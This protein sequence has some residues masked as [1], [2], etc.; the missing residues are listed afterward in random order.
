MA[1]RMYTRRY[2]SYCVRAKHLLDEL[3]VAYQEISVDG[4]AEALAAMKSESGQRTV[5]QIWVG[6]AHIGGCDELMNLYHG[7]RLQGI[8]A[9]AAEAH[10]I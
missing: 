4:D 9:E 1:V 2:C 3:G 8:L 10:E 7:G 6:A 5:P